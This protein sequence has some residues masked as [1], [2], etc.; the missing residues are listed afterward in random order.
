MQTS[1]DNCD[2]SALQEHLHNHQKKIKQ[3]PKISFVLAARASHTAV[4]DS[5]SWRRPYTTAPLSR[6]ATACRVRGSPEQHQTANV[7][8]L[9]ACTQPCRHQTLAT[10]AAPG[11]KDFKEHGLLRLPESSQRQCPIKEHAEQQAAGAWSR[12]RKSAT[13][14]ARETACFHSQ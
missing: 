5:C 10:P 8:A 11:R 14:P 4:G 1:L 9:S 13:A 2:G 12:N 7:N 3:A 6:K